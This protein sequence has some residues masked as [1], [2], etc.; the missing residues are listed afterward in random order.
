MKNKTIEQKKKIK[1]VKTAYIW[2]EL[3]EKYGITGAAVE[4][5]C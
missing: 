3:E 1:F 5:A 2:E 4:A